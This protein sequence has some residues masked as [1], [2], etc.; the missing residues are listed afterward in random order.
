[1]H[2]LRNQWRQNVSAEAILP[3]SKGRLIG[4]R[5]RKRGKRLALTIADFCNKIGTSRRCVAPQSLV[6]FGKT[7]D[8]GTP[9]ALKGSGANDPKMG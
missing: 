8:I 9:W 5:S 3:P 7:A 1:M 6:T 2:V 4:S